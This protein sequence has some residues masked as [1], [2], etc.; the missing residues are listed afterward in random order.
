MSTKK[1]VLVVSYDE[2]LLRQRKLS[3][4]AAGFSVISGYRFAEAS[5]ICRLD[6]SFD[7]VVLGYTVPGNDKVALIELLRTHCKT[8]ILSIRKHGA[9]PLREAEFSIDSDS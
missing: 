8:P 5:R 9:P 6:S 3:L 4:E 2:A 7:L 1:R